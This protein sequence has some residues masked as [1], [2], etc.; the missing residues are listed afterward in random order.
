MAFTAIL[1]PAPAASA[2][3]HPVPIS[4]QYEVTITSETPAMDGLHVTGVAKGQATHLGRLTE[5]E[6]AVIYPDGT[7]EASVVLTA[8]NGDQLFCTDVGG[9][10]SPTTTA[11][12]ITFMGGTGRFT[13]ASGTANFGAV[14]AP[15]GI[16][17]TLTFEGT[18]Q[19]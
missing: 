2:G 16:H 9:F 18:I 15:D 7:L 5:T 1:G 19:Y 14:I 8:A 11:G 13:N 17:Y 10:T 4:G 3:D 12:T 6:N